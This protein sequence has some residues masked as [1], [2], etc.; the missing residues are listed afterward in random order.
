MR[1]L[2]ICLSLSGCVSL[3][4]YAER[5]ETFKGQPIQSVFAKFG[6]PDRQEVIA[7]R[8]VYYW[9]DSHNSCSLRVVATPDRKV[10]SGTVTGS[11]AGCSLFFR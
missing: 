3:Q 4:P 7:D 5:M 10:D 1:R 8:T 11:P 9:G 2:L 6:Y